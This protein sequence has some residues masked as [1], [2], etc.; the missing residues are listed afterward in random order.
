MADIFVRRDPVADPGFN[1]CITM[2]RKATKGAVGLEIEV[3][4]NKFPKPDGYAGT[5]TPVKMP[6]LSFWSYVHDGSL[7]G[8]DN[9]EYILNKPIEFSEIP[10]AMKELFDCLN[11]YGSVL[12][13]SNRTSTHVHLNC[14]EFHLNRLTSL[15]AL[16]YTFEEIL[17]AWCGEHRVG[18]LF[19]LRAMDAPAIIAQLRKFIKND[20]KSALSE[21]LH[22]AGLNAHALHKF[23]S[24]EVR[25]LRGCSDPQTILDWV[26]ILERFY[27]LSA[28]FTDP[29]DICGA[30][31]S[32][33]PL[34]FFDTILGDKVPVVRSAINY[35]DD[36]IRDSMY[37]GVRM[38][39]DL[40][41]CR[42]WS[43]FKPMTLKPDP[44]GRDLKKVV[45][46]ITS[47]PVAVEI[48][49][50]DYESEPEWDSELDADEG[51]LMELQNLA[52]NALY[53]Q[54][55][56]APPTPTINPPHHTTTGI[57]GT[58]AAFANLTWL[59]VTND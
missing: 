7:R 37:A 56:Q 9:A 3:E 38:A 21:H 18:N 5:H 40:C 55:Q 30:F 51:G 26:G 54:A 13:E 25:T 8:V 4:G 24:V 53:Q 49:E 59:D 14:Q 39:Q 44:W 46:K 31:S 35:N 12:D 52:S 58:G 42:D 48:A 29:R 22:Y 17:T 15:M 41:Y 47:A 45:K 34:S 11:A 32:E 36:Q 57:A 43:V 50:A 6:D 19:C 10:A 1:M 27:T 2:G 20:G 33:G 28:E 16:W 23:G